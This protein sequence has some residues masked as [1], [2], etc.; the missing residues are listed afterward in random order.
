ME[1]LSRFSKSLGDNTEQIDSIIGNLNT[2]STQLTE[3]DIVS[4]ISTTVEQL[5]KVLVSVNNGDGSV[6]K[7]LDDAELYDNLT[8][9]SNNLSA[10]LADLQANPHRY[11]NISVFGDNPMK[12]VEKAKAKAEKK[13]IKRAD[14]MAEKGH[15]ERYLALLKNIENGTVFKKTEATT[16]QCRN[17]GHIVVGTKAPQVCPT[18]NHPQSYFEIN[19]SNY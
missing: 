14:E 7:L 13:A 19:A 9:A 1:S 11:I 16:W 8:Q 15:E 18:C 2:F 3:A 17:C 5:N 4:E 10:L 12:K 6:G